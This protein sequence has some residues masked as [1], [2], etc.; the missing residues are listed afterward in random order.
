M[1]EEGVEYTTLNFHRGMDTSGIY[2]QTQK[3]MQSSS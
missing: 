2:L 1:A 3:H